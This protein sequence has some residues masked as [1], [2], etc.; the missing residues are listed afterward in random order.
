MSAI[1][2]VLTE[3]QRQ[4]QVKQELS[5]VVLISKNEQGQIQ[6]LA[7]LYA[8]HDPDINDRS[9]EISWGGS[10]DV[11]GAIG[12][13]IVRCLYDATRRQEEEV[14]ERQ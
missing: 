12:T 9:S 5:L 1:E 10:T 7:S 6:A 8:G 13:A 4:V 3:L 11:H 14:S 2:D